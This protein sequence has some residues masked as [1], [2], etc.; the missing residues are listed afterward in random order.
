M[1]YDRDLS[2]RALEYAKEGYSLTQTAS[3]FKVNISTIIA[4]K[5]RY[6]ATGDVKIKVR[7][8][9][10]EKIIPEKLIKYIEEH[11]DAYLKEIAEVFGRHSSSVLKRLRKFRLREKKSTFYK[12]QYLK[13]VE[14][15]LEKIKD[16]PK[17]KLVYID[18]TGIQMQMYRQH[19]RS[20]RGKRANIHISVK[21]HARI[22]LV[23][24]LC[25]GKLIAPHTYSR[26]M[27]ASLFEKWFEDKLLNN[28]PKDHCH[29]HGQCGVS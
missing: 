21:H 29:H 12:E 18:E 1:S 9:V 16:I 24:A 23:A 6:K 14:A 8:P 4:W 13:Q 19:A 26:T 2:L 17:E 27:M 11:P 5:R 25:A 10:N 22:G 20:K 3:V 7:R 28:F 15:Y